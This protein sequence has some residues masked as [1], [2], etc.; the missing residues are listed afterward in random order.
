MCTYRNVHSEPSDSII[1]HTSGSVPTH[2]N[3]PSL[4][5]ALV[6]TLIIDWSRRPNDDEFT[7]QMEDYTS[8]SVRPY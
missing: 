5:E 6:R 4:V 1:Y 8:V 2:P 3:K 7:L